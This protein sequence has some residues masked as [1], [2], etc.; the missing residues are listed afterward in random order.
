LREA[1]RTAEFFTN[2]GPHVHLRLLA[3]V[4]EFSTEALPLWAAFIAALLGGGGAAEPLPDAAEAGTEDGK[5]QLHMIFQEVVQAWGMM[6]LGRWPKDDLLGASEAAEEALAA[7]D[8]GGPDAGGDGDSGS[9]G[10]ASDAALASLDDG[11][12]SDS[13][14][15]ALGDADR[16]DGGGEGASDAAIDDSESL[17][18]PVPIA[19]A[20]MAGSAVSRIMRKLGLTARRKALAELQF[21]RILTAA[22]D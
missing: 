13:D 4:Y 6:A 11:G 7:L 18:Q 1:L 15:M 22:E 14:A 12:A 21:A 19:V 5:M 10:G 20:S 17:W 9:E 3:S 16:V 2:D 8:E